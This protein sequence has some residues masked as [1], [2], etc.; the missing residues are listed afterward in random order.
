M[1]PVDKE[2][3]HRLRPVL[4]EVLRQEG[5]AHARVHQQEVLV[6]FPAV[7]QR[8]SPGAEV[9]ARVVALEHREVV[10]L[11]ELDGVVSVHDDHVVHVLADAQ[12]RV[13]QHRRLE[14]VH[15]VLLVLVVL[16]EV[17][18][19]DE[20]AIFFLGKAPWHEVGFHHPRRPCDI[21]LG[22]QARL[23]ERVTDEER[24]VRVELIRCVLE[25]GVAVGVGVV[26]ALT[27]L[28]RPV[29]DPVLPQ[30]RLGGQALKV[31]VAIAVS[32]VVAD[33]TASLALHRTMIHEPVPRLLK[34][35]V[36]KLRIA[37]AEVLPPAFRRFAADLVLPAGKLP[38][39]DA[40][41]V[42]VESLEVEARLDHEL[43][44]VGA[45]H[46]EP[47]ARQD[48][49]DGAIHRQRA[50]DEGR[51]VSA[52]LIEAA[53]LAP[54]EP[55]VLG[56]ARGVRLGPEVEPRPGPVLGKDGARQRRVQEDQGAVRPPVQA[57]EGA[58]RS[59]KA[60]PDGAAGPVG[61]VDDLDGVAR[62]GRQLLAE[63]PERFAGG[64]GLPGCGALTLRPRGVQD[65]DVRHVPTI[66]R[67][68]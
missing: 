43:E 4:L 50:V 54:H 47:L 68:R 6:V 53:H 44:E 35:E 40:R 34:G 13:P 25:A 31:C 67:T 19:R 52:A 7:L 48:V 14:E 51:E 58:P 12:A 39:V 64:G 29:L 15:E 3:E 22:G 65:E 62:W 10:Q 41:G 11:R 24:L 37:L 21:A 46:L 42:A 32:H 49:H 28:Q 16:L 57:R 8:F 9:E 18:E 20:D 56:E 2:G 30:L 55:H 38:P 45:Q 33:A 36:R 61:H 26:R 1:G 17:R 63:A 66:V 23:V 59:G 60:V 27:P 5:A